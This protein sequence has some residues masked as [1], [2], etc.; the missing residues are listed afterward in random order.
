MC[1]KEFYVVARHV[2]RENAG[3]RRILAASVLFLSLSALAAT[4]QC[5]GFLQLLLM[6]MARFGALASVT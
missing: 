3:E 4:F 6:N 2:N 1:N 5:R